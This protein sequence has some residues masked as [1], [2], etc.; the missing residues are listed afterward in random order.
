MFL[1]CGIT[2]RNR[3]MKYGFSLKSG[4]VC[5]GSML[6]NSCDKLKLVQMFIG[7]CVDLK[8][9]T[10]LEKFGIGKLDKIV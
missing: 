6:Y 4:L 9:L 3:Q 2:K 10:E 5:F 8:S 7:L 1:L